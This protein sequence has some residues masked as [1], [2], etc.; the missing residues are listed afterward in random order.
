MPEVKGGSRG[1]NGGKQAARGKGAKKPSP[2][3]DA[4]VKQTADASSIIMAIVFLVALLVGTAAW[5]G[6]SM[7]VISG[8]MNTVT[9]GFVKTV[10]LSVKTIRVYDAAPEQ[11]KRILAQMG[12]KQG[13]SMF[14]ADPKQ[15]KS[16]LE[17][18]NG[19]GDIQVHRFWPGQISIF[20]TPLKATVFFWN[21]EQHVA[22]T[23]F[24]ETVPD[25]KFGEVDHPIV[26]GKGAVLA[27]A[28][29]LSDLNDFPAVKSRVS[30]AVRVG[31]RRWDLLMSSGVRIQLPEGAENRF[32][33]LQRLQS[34][35][36]SVQILDRK[37]ANVDLRDPARIYS[38]RAQQLTANLQ[39]AGG[40][41]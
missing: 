27:S 23:P 28:D 26:S 16:R 41:G 24:G 1:R 29:L 3:R 37:I 40:K 12:V 25:V 39:Q 30:R 5:M 4:V 15:I 11:E 8:G 32:E 10:G 31:E 13:D 17:K 20:V 2:A 22:M 36:Q 34:L 7:S 33:A 6:Q 9:D 14:R 18:I 19:L 35:Q 21:G 38:R